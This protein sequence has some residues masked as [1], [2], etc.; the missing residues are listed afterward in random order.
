MC[1]KLI[2]LF[3]MIAFLLPLSM[4]LAEEGTP[5]DLTISSVPSPDSIWPASQ[6]TSDGF[7]VSGEF[8]YASEEEGLWRYC[9]PT[10]KVE[11]VRHQQYK[12]DKPLRWY[13]A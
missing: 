1:R 3:L 2:S 8:V 6:M 11:I 9:S 10:L 4:T 7:L 12:P 5:T 13:E